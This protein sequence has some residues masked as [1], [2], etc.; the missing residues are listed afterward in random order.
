[1]SRMGQELERL[2]DENKYE[3]YYALKELRQWLQSDGVKIL[4]EGLY[5]QMEMS[6]SFERVDNIIN[7][8]EGMID[9]S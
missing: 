1:M 6:K 2:L 7:K 5:E 9:D 8:I 4:G 3:L